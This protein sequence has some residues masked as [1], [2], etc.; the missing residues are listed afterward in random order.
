MFQPKNFQIHTFHDTINNG[1]M[2]LVLSKNTFFIV[3]PCVNYKTIRSLIENK[4]CAGIFLTHA[5]YDHFN[6]AQDY[7]DK[8]YTFYMHQNAKEKLLNKDGLCTEFF[9]NPVIPNFEN[10][11]IKTIK[12]NDII[13]IDETPLK[14]IEL[15]GHTDCSVGFLIDNCFFVGDCVFADGNIGRFDLKT[16]SGFQTRR[17][18]KKLKTFDLYLDIFPGHGDKFTL[19]NFWNR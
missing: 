7:I 13:E 14:V 10:A 3:D 2:Y 8:N 17:T 19:K 6:A 15:F 12:E 4:K 1:N 18:L 5:H 9:I 16:G 11:K